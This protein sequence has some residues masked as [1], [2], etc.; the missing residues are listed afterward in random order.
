MTSLNKYSQQGATLLV[1]LMLLVIMMIMGLSIASR[2]TAR[3]QVAN[4]S[5]LQAQAEQAA[6][7]GSDVLLSLLN[8]TKPEIPSCKNSYNAQYQGSTIA[9]S[10]ADDDFRKITL[11]WYACKPDTTPSC[12]GDV[13]E[14]EA[15]VITGVACFD[16]SSITDSST[17]EGCTVRRY[18]QGYGTKT[19]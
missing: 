5:V 6:S 16:G 14:C 4:G 2:T 19:N 17:R 11:T 15:F 8:D 13:N 1:V 12:G 7:I 3:T 9:S 18:L 10:S